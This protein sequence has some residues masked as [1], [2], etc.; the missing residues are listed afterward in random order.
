MQ[1]TQA[2]GGWISALGATT[3]FI[4]LGSPWENGNR[5]SFNARYRDKQLNGEIVYSLKEAQI[6]IE[7]WRRYHNMIRPHSALGY[8]RR[9]P[10]AVV[11]LDERPVVN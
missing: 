1:V 9:T 6:I 5:E 7:R 3:A 2:I 11:A 8:S 4:E 10:E